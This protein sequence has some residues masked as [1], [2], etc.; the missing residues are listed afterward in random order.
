M[1][2][3]QKDK[4]NFKKRYT[5]TMFLS[6]TV[7]DIHFV[8]VLMFRT[9]DLCGN[10]VNTSFALCFFLNL[11]TSFLFVSGLPVRCE[12][13]CLPLSPGSIWCGVC[14]ISGWKYH[15]LWLCRCLFLVLSKQCVVC[16]IYDI[17]VYFNMFIRIT[18]NI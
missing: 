10:H 1:K 13:W 11:I 4:R 9:G 5:K 6:L 17:H 12:D 3:W 16:T 7:S 18:F 15:K 8:L 2:H 14:K